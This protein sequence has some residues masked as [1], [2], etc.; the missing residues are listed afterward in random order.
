V[1]HIITGG[2]N[3]RME[4]EI[5]RENDAMYA[6]DHHPQHDN[7]G[8][9]NARIIAPGDPDR[10]VL[11]HRMSRRGRGQMPPLVSNAVDVQAVE[12]MGQWIKSLPPLRKFVR[13]WTVE[14]LHADLGELPSGEAVDR[15]KVVF[16]DAGC[17]QCH[18]RSND[19]G[20]SGPDLTSLVQ[21]RK[22]TEVIESIVLPS[23]TVAAEFTSYQIETVDG[24]VHV[25]RI[26]REDDRVLVIRTTNSF[27][28][29][30]EVLKEDVEEIAKS[31]VSTMPVGL[32]DTWELSQIADL[33]AFLMEPEPVAPLPTTGTP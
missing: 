24:Q 5:T 23:K 20:G 22:L 10:S 17:I 28:A 29:P 25:G 14:Q 9:P 3:S 15:G 31:P 12:V 33:L 19:G 18:R 32:L 4:F 11:Y 7:L 27:Q 2:G 13:A 21:R 30:I 26:E 16:R 6:I 8:L 1:C